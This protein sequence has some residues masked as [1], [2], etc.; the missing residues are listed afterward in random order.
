MASVEVAD[1]KFFKRGVGA[2]ILPEHLTG[3]LYQLFKSDCECC[4]GAS[5]TPAI[6]AT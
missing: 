2:T 3:Y 4:E 6:V 1:V 5:S